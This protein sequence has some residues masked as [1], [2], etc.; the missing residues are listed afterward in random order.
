MIK[1]RYWIYCLE[2]LSIIIIYLIIKVHV[3]NGEYIDWKHELLVSVCWSL[4]LT[5]FTAY[6]KHIGKRQNKQ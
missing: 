1:K 4:V 2:F 5:G 6:G 3:S